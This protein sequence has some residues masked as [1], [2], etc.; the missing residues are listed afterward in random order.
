MAEDSQN[1][2]LESQIT[3]EAD[4]EQS[5]LQTSDG[6]AE[7]GQEAPASDSAADSGPDLAT[8][9]RARV[10]EFS[11]NLKWKEDLLLSCL[12][13]DIDEAYRQSWLEDA[14]MFFR[15][16]AIIKKRLD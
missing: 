13:G 16:A 11:G 3:S 8:A 1:A 7:L 10:D 2:D 6:N 15:R 9:L 12:S 4:E 5:P 14:N